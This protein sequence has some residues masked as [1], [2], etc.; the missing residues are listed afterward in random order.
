MPA[1]GEGF[2]LQM[3]IVEDVERIGKTGAAFKIMSRE[4]RID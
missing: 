4:Q 2:P 3:F 1:L